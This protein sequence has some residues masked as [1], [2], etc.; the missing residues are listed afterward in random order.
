[1]INET[2]SIQTGSTIL[3]SSIILTDELQGVNEAKIQVVFLDRDGVINV[4]RDDYV[5][6]WSEFEFL[7]GAK[8]AIKMLNETNYWV[9]IVTNQSPIG[10]GIFDHNTLEEI[11]TKMLQELSDAGAHIDAIYYCPHSPDDE[12]GCRKPKPGL[13]IRAA[14]ELNIDLNN[15]WL[16]GDSDGDIEAGKAAGC[17]TFK[18]TEINGLIDIVKTIIA[19]EK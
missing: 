11:H 12:C 5:K 8:D 19:N 1:M 3:P 14:E 13:L 18:V 6:S 2:N 7:P 10:R 4:N 9:I 15:S 16:I 17:K